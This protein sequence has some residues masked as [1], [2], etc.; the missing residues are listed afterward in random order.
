MDC[1]C[2]C[3]IPQTCIDLGDFNEWIFR[4][5]SDQLGLTTET[6]PAH[7][8]F[9]TRIKNELSI[10]FLWKSYRVSTVKHT[11]WLTSQIDAEAS[12]APTAK[13]LPLVSNSI[14]MQ[15]PVCAVKQCNSSK[16]LSFSFWMAGALMGD[17]SNRKYL[18]IVD[19]TYSKNTTD[20]C[21]VVTANSCPDRSQ[22]ISFT[23]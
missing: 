7:C 19:R 23:S 21:P 12:A 17:W 18:I 2:S 22:E 6:H 9:N 11:N 10:L 8:P 5:Q 20:P 14:Q 3:E 16:G 13:Y 1:V 15:F 4:S